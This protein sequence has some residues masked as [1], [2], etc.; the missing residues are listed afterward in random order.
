MKYLSWK[1]TAAGIGMIVTALFTMILQPLT[2][3]NPATNPDYNVAIAS[4]IAGIGL[5]MARDDNRSSEEVGAKVG[6]HP[7]PTGE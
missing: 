3:G 2:D 1:T 4:I 6:E 7:R 5:V